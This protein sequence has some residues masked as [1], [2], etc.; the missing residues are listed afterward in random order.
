MQLSGQTLTL[1]EIG[2]V[3]L[4]DAAVQTSRSARPRILASRK[5]I[6]EIIAR[7][8]VVY[9]VS[10]GFGKLSDVRIAHDALAELQLNLVR[11]HACGIGNPLSE[12]EVRAMMLLRA[13][14]LALGLS[15]IRFEIIEMLCK[16]LNRRVCPVVPEKGSVGAS[17]DLAPL[18]HLAL[19]LIGEG[20]AFFQGERMESREAFRLAGLEPVELQAKEGL[21]LLNGTQAMHAVGGLALLRA[22]RLARLADVSGAMSLEAL[23]GTPVAFDLR[24]QDARPHPGQK[25]VAKHLLSLLEGSEIRQS[26]L[27]NDPRIQDAYS[28]RCMPQVHGAVRGALAHCEDILIVES[29]SATDNPLVFAEAMDG[30]PGKGEVIS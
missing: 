3:A 25:A 10:T 8:D 30:E 18:A 5:V 28:L 23:K 1:A 27:T 22:K 12:P 26:H 11:S 4:G 19:S 17:G 6:E 13:N 20:E 9:G 2:A 24:L 7:D 21:A 29:A 14:V 16:M 15:G